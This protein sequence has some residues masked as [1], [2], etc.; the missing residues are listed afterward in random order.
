MSKGQARLLCYAVDSASSDRDGYR[1]KI[2]R[3]ERRLRQL[4]LEP[5]ILDGIEVKEKILGVNAIS[6]WV[7]ICPSCL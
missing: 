4:L 3:C 7:G 2:P 6:S 5:G 1:A